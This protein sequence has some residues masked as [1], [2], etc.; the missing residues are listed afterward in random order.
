MSTAVEGRERRLLRDL[1]DALRRGGQLMV[2][3]M[4]TVDLATADMVGLEALVRWEHPDLGIVLPLDFV[5][6]AERH[7][8]AAA[9]GNHVRGLVVDDVLAD[10]LPADNV[11]V[12]VSGAEL[13]DPT[14]SDRMLDLLEQRGLDPAQ[15]TVEVTETALAADV[16]R[17]A[18][19]LLRLRAAGF[20]IAIDD[21]GTGHASLDYLVNLPCDIVKID[22]V[23][24]SGLVTDQRCTAI[25][26]GVIG[27]AH[28]LG[29]TVVAEGVETSSQRD[30]LIDLG[31]EQAQGYLFG[32][33]V[34][35]AK[36]PGR[37]ATLGRTTAPPRPL[38]VSKRSTPH[39]TAQ[40]LLD[41][42]V[43]LE[44]CTDLH[45]ALNCTL[46]GLR[47]HIL[48]TGGSVQLT[49][50]DGIR[51]AAAHPPPTPG[52]LAA[53]LP[54]GQGVGWGIVMSLELRY[55]PDIAAPAAPVQGR[56]RRSSTTRHT[57]SYLGVPLLVDGRAIGLIQIDSVDVDAFDFTDQLLLAGCSCILATVIAKR[58]WAS[59]GAG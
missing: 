30:H 52:A 45:D 24:T 17:A 19:A 56:R 42:A 43:D 32:K 4:P 36:L 26:R 44:N 23:F 58:G 13:S 53:R 14:F 37:G 50:P 59:V 12:N 46:Q 8:M 55:L 57:R 34:S 28:G 18:E 11:A 51:L 35:T 38:I 39:F 27:M 20:S 7:G 25:V 2:H 5:P 33:P 49:G 54:A 15:L 40:V 6:L 16:G 41:L 10:R 9:L 48:F 47:P 3:Y 1:P 31:C 22:R 21:F 29:L